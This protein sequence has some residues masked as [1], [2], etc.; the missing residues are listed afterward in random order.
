MSEKKS[1]ELLIYLLIIKY[2]TIFQLYC[3]K[4]K[5]ITNRL[6]FKVIVLRIKK[7]FYNILYQ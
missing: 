5:K 3:N 6:Q 7:L 1:Y 4:K 2:K